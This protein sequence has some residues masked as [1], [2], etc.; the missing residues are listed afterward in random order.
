MSIIGDHHALHATILAG[1]LDG[2]TT[3]IQRILEQLLD[4]VTRSMNDL[5]DRHK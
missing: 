1:D 2:R 3:C 5:Q 4:G